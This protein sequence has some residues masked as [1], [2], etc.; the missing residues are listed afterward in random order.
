MSNRSVAYHGLTTSSTPAASRDTRRRTRVVAVAASIIAALAVWLVA[1]TVIGVSFTIPVAGGTRTM[2]VGWVSVIVIT[3]AL[4]LAAW[5]LLAVLERFTP[6]ARMIWAAIA[7]AALLLSFA[8]P[9]FA[10][11][12]A[13]AGTKVSLVLMHVAVA[14]VLIPLLARTA[15]CRPGVETI[16]RQADDDRS[17]S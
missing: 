17:L 5:G 9:L 12:A 6:R 13:S 16:G 2:P 1:K 15:A 3:L 11:G 10:A 7:S 8:G 14:V 4:T